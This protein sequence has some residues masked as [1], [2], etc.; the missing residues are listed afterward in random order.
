MSDNVTPRPWVA[1]PKTP[2][3]ATICRVGPASI[4][5]DNEIGDDYADARHIV[6]CVN[7]HNLLKEKLSRLCAACENLEYEAGRVDLPLQDAENLLNLL[8]QLEQTHD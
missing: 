4:E 5:T 2:M 3:A 1:N 6:R 7:Y 8:E